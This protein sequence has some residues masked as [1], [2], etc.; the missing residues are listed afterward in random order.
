MSSTVTI[1]EPRKA[2]HS[3][4]R[5]VHVKLN[6][7]VPPSIAGT[8]WSLHTYGLKPRHRA[9]NS[10]SLSFVPLTTLDAQ[11]RPWVS[12]VSRRDGEK[13]FISSPDANTLVMEVD[14]FSDDPLEANL[15]AL[16]QPG[17]ILVA[18]LGIEPVT[19]D[20]NK[21]AG[22]MVVKKLSTDSKYQL[23]LMVNQSIG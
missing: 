23:Q 6:G 14:V 13:G 10:T 4:E 7:Q 8:G 17:A 9:F 2:W 18:G 22:T 21:F 16:G 15:A 11:G 20:R 5:A 12:L 1:L 19:R 3:G